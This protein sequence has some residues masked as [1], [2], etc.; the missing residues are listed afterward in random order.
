MTILGIVIGVAAVTII[1]SVGRS[2]QEL[3]LGQLSGLGSNL[4]AIIPGKET[5]SGAPAAAM[6]IIT[7]TLTNED[8][9]MLR[10]KRNAPH[11]T[12]I[13]GY[14]TGN[15][16]VK[17]D[18]YSGKITFYGV[19]PDI[20]HVEDINIAYGRFF[21]FSDNARL[22]RVA[23]LGSQRAKDLF[24]GVSPLGKD[25]S[26][27][28]EKF[29]VIGVLSP[30]GAVA[31]VNQDANIYIP[32]RTAQKRLLNIDYL[33]LARAKV[34]N[35]KNIPQTVED[36]DKL[37]SIRHDI[38]PGESR[39][40]TIKDTVSALGMIT[41]ITNILNYFLATVAAIALLVGGIGVMNI[42][43]IILSQ[44][45]REIGL[46]KSLG[47]TK[48]DIAGQFLLESVIISFIGGIVGI[49]VGVIITVIIGFIIGGLGYDYDL[50]ISW[51]AIGWALIISIIVGI[52]FGAYPAWRASGTSPMEAL[53]YE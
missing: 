11:I 19:S 25:I 17:S 36:I 40:F 16:T 43:F 3:I 5:D 9:K 53:R 32:L 31:F 24:G 26:I 27:K 51:K 41:D 20:V 7:K 50:I 15:A 18:N 33:N 47:A 48:A 22:R 4:V 34:N 44:R 23:V 49:V 30:R 21:D 14:V 28:G 10:Q 13:S 42:M 8:L 39:D 37:L 52:V 38:A 46:R 12:A 2:A 45:V 35:E 29:V 6:G 1:S